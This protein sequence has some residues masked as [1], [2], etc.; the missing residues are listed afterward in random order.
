MQGQTFSHWHAVILSAILSAVAGLVPVIGNF[1]RSRD[2]LLGIEDWA[3]FFFR[4]MVPIFS[5][6]AILYPVF[7]FLVSHGLGLLSSLGVWPGII[8][9]ELRSGLLPARISS[10][11]VGAEGLRITQEVSS[12][13]QRRD[14]EELA[15][16]F[17]EV[18]ELRKVSIQEVYRNRHAHLF[19]G[20]FQT[21]FFLWA[22]FVYWATTQRT[23]ANIWPT[24]LAF[25]LFFVI[26]DWRTIFGLSLALKGQ[27]PQGQVVSVWIFNAALLLLGAA[28]LFQVSSLLA[29]VLVF[30]GAALLFYSG[31]FWFGYQVPWL[32]TYF[33]GTL[34][35]KSWP[36]D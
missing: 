30:V 10:I 17:P 27:I 20:I 35:W 25:A 12:F 6:F 2:L 33:T 34:D 29:T 3:L 14:I 15:M 4:S 23:S 11:L 28:S 19:L 18:A 21:G 8:S 22:T 24:L 16:E 36:N 32:T 9:A 26:D 31:Y 5:L 13:E 1:R 7:E